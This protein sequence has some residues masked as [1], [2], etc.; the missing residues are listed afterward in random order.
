MVTFIV[1]I[2]T[3]FLL[4]YDFK[5]KALEYEPEPPVYSRLYF[6]QLFKLLLLRAMPKNM[7]HR[8]S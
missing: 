5:V 7:L 3:L 6:S 8:C 4:A 1:L 2:L